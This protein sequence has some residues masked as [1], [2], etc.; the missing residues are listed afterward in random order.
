MTIN[1]TKYDK[2]VIL[3]EF[4]DFLDKKDDQI[5]VSIFS[6]E[7]SPLEATVKYLI[8][9]K[10]HSYSECGRLLN[11]DR[12]VIWTTFKRAE[13]KSEKKFQNLA[14]KYSI[15]LSELNSETKSMAELVVSYLKN[16]H[17]LKITEIAK[18]LKR[19]QKT[20]W[21]LQKRAEKKGEDAK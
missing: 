21:T 14:S 15:P 5:P 9:E 13:K 4:S 16:K 8:S 12:Q 17:S 20:I 1:L 11:K 6:G 2:N 7:L 10:N 19:S 3:E 18:L